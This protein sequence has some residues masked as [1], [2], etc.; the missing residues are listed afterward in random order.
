[1]FYSIISFKFAHMERDFNI[2]ENEGVAN[3]RIAGII[4]E[5]EWVGAYSDEE[6]KNA[7]KD[8]LRKELKAILDV[9][10]K[11]INLEMGSLGGSTRHSTAMIANLATVKKQLDA[12][13]NLS[14]TENSASAATHFG[15]V[16]DTISC[17]E[18]LMLL[19]HEARGN[20]YGTSE[21]IEASLNSLKKID[22]EKIKGYVSQ[23]KRAGKNKTAEDFRE[24]MSRGKG[25][26][27]W[28]NVDELLEYGLITKITP[29]YD[30][31]NSL[32]DTND[33]EILNKFNLPEL[34]NI[35]KPNKN[36]KMGLFD[37]KFNSFN[38]DDVTAV[39]EGKLSK[40]T[41]LSVLN[42]GE[43]KDG[44]YEVNGHS[45]D[46]VANKVTNYTKIAKKEDAVNIA[47]FKD[48]VAD[49]KKTAIE[50]ASEIEKQA[51]SIDALTELVT[52]LS[53]QISDLITEGSPIVVPKN[54]HAEGGDPETYDAIKE[55]RKRIKAKADARREA[56]K[57]ND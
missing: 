49:V 29:V 45:V 22:D 41:E 32:Y 35:T 18:N 24:L 6:Q 47:D 4:G 31:V 44:A 55:S 27:D 36:Q 23:S 14:Y 9:K 39:Y 10:S 50:T 20:A 54:E 12:T 26:G 33:K 43:L 13:I 30:A 52:G 34:P 7:T 1:M 16:A 48:E 21:E 56:N 11:T 25:N 3:I 5:P 53:N 8:E 15:F 42:G 17:P 37:K 28:L 40:G 51:E 2:V 38:A 19:V 46:V 57:L